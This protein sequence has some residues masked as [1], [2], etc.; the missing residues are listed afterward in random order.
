M[1]RTSPHLAGLLTPIK[2]KVLA[3]TL[4]HPDRAWYLLELARCLSIPVSSIQHE[5]GVFVASGLLTRHKDGNRV[6]YQA[7]RRC[8]I[9]PELSKMLVKT[10]GVVDVLKRALSG[11]ASHIDVAFLYGSIASSQEQTESDIDLMVVGDVQL[12]DLSSVLLRGVEPQ[13]GRSVNPTVYTTQEFQRKVKEGHHFLTSVLEKEILFV[14][15]AA[16]DLA[17]LTRRTARATASDKPAGN[18]RPQRG[19]RQRS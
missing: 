13:L 6:Y 11:L 12:L 7:D 14:H 8:P 18:T 10:M 17:N 5:L 9:Y 4:L 1:V 3:A 15:G 19:R 2:Q 16:D